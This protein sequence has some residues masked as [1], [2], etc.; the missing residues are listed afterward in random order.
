MKLMCLTVL[1]VAGFFGPSA[2]ADDLNVV[3]FTLSTTGSFSSGTPKNLAFYGATLSGETDED[4]FLAL[5]NLGTFTLTEPDKGTKNFHPKSDTFEL[6]LTF[7]APLGIKGSTVFDATLTGKV[8]RDGGS[9]F[10]DFGPIQSFTFKNDTASGGFDLT[11]NDITLKLSDDE[12]DVSQVLTGKITNA[13]DPPAAVPEPQAVVLLATVVLLT[14]L[15]LR[16]R[17]AHRG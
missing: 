15:V 4:G 2:F 10:I 9:V 16:R 14:S 5:G 17:P 13:F 12:H 8:K 1:L 6:D 7:L 3:P 11:L